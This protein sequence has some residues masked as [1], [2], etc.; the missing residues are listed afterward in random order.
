M[1]SIMERIEELESKGFKRWQKGTMDRMYINASS[2]GLECDYYK[3]GNIRSASFNGHDVSNSEGY[4]IKAAKT[5]IDLVKG[6]LVSDN[7]YCFEAA[8]QLIGLG[9]YRFGDNRA[10][11]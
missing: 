1:T 4:R 6:E 2:L 9:N 10:T 5:Y 11:I 3:T 8:A 7:D